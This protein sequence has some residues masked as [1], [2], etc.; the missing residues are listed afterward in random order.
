[1]E[2]E[3]QIRMFCTTK[4]CQLIELS[5]WIP[6]RDFRNIISSSGQQSF[7]TIRLALV[8]ESELSSSLDYD[9]IYITRNLNDTRYGRFCK[10]VWRTSEVLVQ[11]IDRDKL[12]Q[13][14]KEE[15]TILRKEITTLR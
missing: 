6:D 9:E 2:L 7:N 15:F 5:I 8:L 10:A 13:L 1:M 3:F 4:M 12:Q 14:T 11:E